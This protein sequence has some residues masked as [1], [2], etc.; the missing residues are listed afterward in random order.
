MPNPFKRW[1]K[2][3]YKKRTK[4]KCAVCGKLTTGRIPGTGRGGTKGDTSFRFPRRHKV[5]GKDC[6]GNIIEA[7]WIDN[8]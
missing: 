6:P 3:P 7:E 5:N 8:S 1:G 2:G 4:F